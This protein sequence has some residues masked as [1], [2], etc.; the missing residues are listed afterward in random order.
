M[1][2]TIDDDDDENDDDDDDDDDEFIIFQIM[3]KVFPKSKILGERR[4]SFTCTLK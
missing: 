2:K 1:I 4:S 3:I